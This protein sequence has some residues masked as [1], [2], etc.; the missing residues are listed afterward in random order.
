MGTSPLQEI[1]GAMASSPAPFPTLLISVNRCRSVDRSS[2]PLMA[3]SVILTKSH[4]NMRRRN[5]GLS[6]AFSASLRD[7]CVPGRCPGLALKSRRWRFGA[8]VGT[9]SS[10]ES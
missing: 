2:H 3:P 9:Q 6:R 1:A 5:L 4:I 7:C 8:G 10:H